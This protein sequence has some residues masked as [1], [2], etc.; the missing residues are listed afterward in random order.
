VRED[1]VASIQNKGLLG[2]KMLEFTVGAG[3]P[4]PAEAQIKSE[5]PVDFSK[6]LTQLDSIAKKA[7]EAVG[8]V[9]KMTGAL[10]DENVATDVKGTFQALK[11]I[12]EGIAHKDGAAHRLIFDQETGKHLDHTLA[13]IDALTA[14]L[15]ATTTDVHDITQRVKDGPGLVHTLVYDDALGQHTVGVLAEL[16]SDLTAVRE[17]NG[18]VHALVYGDSNTQHVMGNVNAMTDDLRKIVADVKAGKGTLG[19]LLVDPSIYE[20]IKSVVGNVDRNQVLRAL[21]RYSIKADEK[22]P[23]P[24]AVTP[25]P[26]K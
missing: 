20:D 19:G 25:A 15:N 17:G 14:N 24:P 7:D 22:A 23:A 12:L 3:S 4:L 18:I 8:N 5:D 10:A 11:E 1:T 26:P 2:D 16:H 21:V 6:Y 13:N 9:A